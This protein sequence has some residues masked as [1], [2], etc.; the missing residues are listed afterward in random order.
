MR[1]I[2]RGR[3]IFESLGYIV[4]VIN[5]AVKSVDPTSPVSLV[6]R[7]CH[8]FSDKSSDSDTAVN[9]FRLLLNVESDKN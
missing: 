1:E 9:K 8:K 2:I 5:I 4:I 7:W 3:E 6:K